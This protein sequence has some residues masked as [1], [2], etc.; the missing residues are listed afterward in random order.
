MRLLYYNWVPFDDPERRSGGVR[1]YQANLID[2]LVATTDHE[3]FTVASGVE[4][5]KLRQDMRFEQTEN[6][7]G[8]RVASFRF[9]N[10]PV[11]APG[12]HAFDSEHIFDE[13]R[14]LA[15]WHD[16]LREH[17]PF[18]V[19]QFD[20]LEGIPFTWLRVHEVFPRTR[21]LLYTHNYHA[22]CPQVNLWK[23]EKEHCTDYHDGKDCATC[24]PHPPN[25]NDILRAH[26]LSRMLRTAGIAP[27][28]WS[29]RAAYGVYART[30]H[31]GTNGG[32][33]RVATKSILGSAD[34]A[35][36]A[37]D[38]VRRLTSRSVRRVTARNEATPPVA[39]PEPRLAGAPRRT[40]RSADSGPEAPTAVSLKKDPM[41]RRR[42]EFGADLINREVDL[43]L[44]T[45]HRTAAVLAERGIDPGHIEVCYIGT[46]VADRVDPTL[47][48]TEPR[49][50]G[51]LT[52]AYL[53]Y[54]R[55]DKGFAF[56]MKALK[57]APEELLAR[58]RLVV[59]AKRTDEKMF[60]RLESIAQYLGDV[61][62]FNGYTHADLPAILETVDVGLVPVQWED[63]LP[64][65]AIEMMANG[66]PLLTSDRGGAQEL[67]GR[68][69]D[70]T[71]TSTSIDSFLE[72]LQAL[73]DGTTALGGFWDHARTLQTMAA[74]TAQLMGLYAPDDVNLDAAS[75][76][77]PRPLRS[78]GD[79]P[80][81]PS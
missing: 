53:G 59:A 61:V 2:H 47:R 55:R 43:V 30:K 67:G 71:F 4:H 75:I 3:I 54:M 72:R 69:P 26:Q 63:N 25:V 9:V 70:F 37:Q 44:A 42:R 64:Q 18:D 11:M 12:H 41:F 29:Y 57:R 74:H 17:G 13:G 56:L 28:T 48:R 21:V 36:R 10:S 7:H 33:Y 38:N 77:G 8:Q 76:D 6:A 79:G 46:K 51:K 27:G 78:P 20:S 40:P 52:L 22:V 50:P 35:R 34:L 14:V 73:V 5:D 49:E 60:E 80:D 24:L 15:I 62:H 68:N 31:L 66:V 1:L 32:L 19:V 81:A 58:L 45:S 39:L 65:V 23:N 16:F